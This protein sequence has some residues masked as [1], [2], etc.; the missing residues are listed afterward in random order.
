MFEREHGIIIACDVE[1]IEKLKEL[2]EK[3]YGI[4]GI[5]G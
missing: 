2:V 3:T 4:D 1:N 5:V